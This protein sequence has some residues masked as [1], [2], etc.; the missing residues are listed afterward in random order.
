[1][2]NLC[3][4]WP[5]LSCFIF[6]RKILLDRLGTRNVD[7]DSRK[8]QLQNRQLRNGRRKVLRRVDGRRRKR[9]I[10]GGR[11]SKRVRKKRIVRLAI[12]RR[13]RG[14]WKNC[15]PGCWKNYVFS[16]DRWFSRRYQR[17]LRL[18]SPRHAKARARRCIIPAARWICTFLSSTADSAWKLRRRPDGAAGQTNE[19]PELTTPCWF[20]GISVV[21]PPIGNAYSLNSPSLSLSEY[22]TNFQTKYLV[23]CVPSFWLVNFFLCY[24]TFVRRRERNGGLGTVARSFNPLPFSRKYLSMTMNE[25][26]EWKGEKR[27][28][29]K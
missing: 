2:P 23:L 12:G 11:A 3:A 25:L 1:M 26:I 17:R 9:P 28:E 19:E 6:E 16:V 29:G 5:I 8:T 24:V 4:P 13:A 15:V 18:N 20:A 10:D 14:W 22:F 21:I 27:I 7:E